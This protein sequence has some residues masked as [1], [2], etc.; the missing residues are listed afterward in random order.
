MAKSGNFSS[1]LNSALFLPG[2]GTERE[3]SALSRGCNKE[4]RFGL[5]R[6]AVNGTKDLGISRTRFA[7]HVL[8][9]FVADSNKHSFARI[10]K[11]AREI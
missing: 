4:P 10:R 7:R 1:S 11:T 9:V 3:L 8:K 2:I 6:K 5:L